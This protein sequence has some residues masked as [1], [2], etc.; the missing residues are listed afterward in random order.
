[1]LLLHTCC[2]DC[3]LK[4]TAVLEVP[5]TLYFYNPNIHPESEFHARRQALQTVFKAKGYPVIIAPWQP[6]HFF[7]ALK[8]EQ[9]FP[10]R[11]SLCWRLRLEHT[12]AYAKAHD[13][14][15]VSTTLLSS[16]YHD[17]AK[18]TAIGK[19]LAKHY[20]LEFVLPT[21]INQDQCT[22]GFYKQNYAGCVYSLLEK[23]HQKYLTKP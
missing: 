19:K 9:R 11:C 20:Q 5:T 12:F 23:L 13:F 8:G 14:N 4:L 10:L 17:R 7:T 18:I 21:T 1:M 16:L 6:A 22:A 2:A 15:Q 3:A